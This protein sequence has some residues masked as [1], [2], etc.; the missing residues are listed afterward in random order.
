MTDTDRG[1]PGTGRFQ[2]YHERGDGFA[3][4]KEQRCVTMQEKGGR[5][6]TVES[7]N[8]VILQVSELDTFTTDMAT[9]KVT[10]A[11]S[12]GVCKA[13]AGR[14]PKSTSKGKRGKYR[15]RFTSPLLRPSQCAVA[16]L[17]FNYIVSCS[18]WTNRLII[19]SAVSTFYDSLRYESQWLKDGFLHGYWVF[20]TMFSAA[21]MYAHG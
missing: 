20:P 1:R 3:R 14:G 19:Y 17:F 13:Q 8:G 4:V 12:I 18:I 10:R 6:L 11:Q 2:P 5:E 21:I 9:R 16:C 15:G 7:A